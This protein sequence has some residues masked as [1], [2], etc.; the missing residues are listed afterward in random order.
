[1][2]V[3]KEGTIEYLESRIKSNDELIKHHEDRLKRNPEDQES[4]ETIKSLE[5]ANEKFR[6][7]IAAFHSVK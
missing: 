3:S 6:E 5:D 1:M 7:D 2:A 4:I